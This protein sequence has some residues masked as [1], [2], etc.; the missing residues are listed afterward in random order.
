[1]DPL[2]LQ[3]DRRERLKEA[4]MKIAGETETLL[5]DRRD[6]HRLKQSALVELR[7]QQVCR[8]VGEH[9]IVVRDVVAVEDEEAAVRLLR[10]DR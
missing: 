4:V 6:A 7:R 9:E 5:A 8:D 1:M 3:L 2:E 10:L